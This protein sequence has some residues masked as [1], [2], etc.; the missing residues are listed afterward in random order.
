MNNQLRSFSLS[1]LIRENVFYIFLLIPFHN[2]ANTILNNSDYDLLD[3]NTSPIITCPSNYF[4]C[5][6]DDINPDNT[7]YATA[8]PGESGCDD[9]VVSYTDVIL[10]EGPCNGQL[11]IKRVWLAEY[12]NNMD[13]WLIAECTQIILLED[14][15]TPTI[16]NCPADITL[17]LSGD[18][19]NPEWDEPTASDNCLL[20]S[21]NSNYN[22]GDHFPLGETVVIYTAKDGCG[23]TSSCSFTVTITG[24][25]CDTAPEILC[26]DHVNICP[27][28][29]ISPD[30]LGFASAVG[31]SI[32]GDIIIEYEDIITNNDNNCTGHPRIRRNWTAYYSE[33]PD[34]ISTCVQRITPKDLEAP[35]FESCPSNIT[36]D[37]EGECQGIVSWIE[38]IVLDECGIMSLTSNYQSGDLFDAGTYTVV[39]TA[40]DSC[41][42]ES[43]CSFNVT[44]LDN[45]C[46]ADPIISC[47]S[48]IMNCIGSSIHPDQ[49]GYPI[50]TIGEAGCSLPDVSYEDV[51]ISS[52]PCPGGKVIARTWTAVDPN[53]NSLLASCTQMIELTDIVDPVIVD[54]PGD[55]VFNYG[56]N[57]TWDPPQVY[58]DCGVASFESNYEPGDNLPLGTTLIKY[59]AVDECGNTA[60][61]SFY[62]TITNTDIELICPDDITISCGQDIADYDLTPIF[63]TS[64]SLCNG[65]NE[66]S[67]FI[68][69]GSL[70]GHK[71]YCSLYPTTWEAAQAACETYGGYLAC[72]NSQEENY[73]LSSF[74][75][76]Q[77]AYIGFSDTEQ[78]GEFKWVSGEAV[79]Y[80]NWYPGQPNDYQ[81]G[82][83]HVEMLYTGQWNDQYP[84][85][86]LEF[87]MEI[88]C[89][90][91]IQ[92]GGPD[93]SYD[94][95]TGTHTIT[96]TG[97]DACGNTASC[98]FN[99]TVEASLEVDC[100]DDLV[101][102]CPYNSGGVVVNWNEPE[103][104]TCCGSSNG[105]DIPGFIYMGSFNG[106]SYYCTLQPYTWE[107]GQALCE[108][109]GGYLTN[110]ET[111]EE[112]Q[113]LADI[114]TIQSAYI[115]L[116]DSNQE[117][118]FEWTTGAPLN[119][120]NWYP[121]QPNDFNNIQDYVEMLGSGLWNDQYYYK[122]LECI[123]EIPGS[124]NI[125]Q[126]AGPPSGSYFEKGTTTT[127]TYQISDGCGNLE[128]C[129]FDI[130]I[131][132]NDCSPLGMNSET[133][134]IDGVAFNELSNLSGNN[135]GYGDFTNICYPAQAGFSYPI[136]LNP[137]CISAS[138]HKKYWTI[139]MDFNM[140]G[141][142]FDTN[143]FVA[144]GSGVG[145][146][147]GVI[148]LPFNIWNG[149]V[150]MR[151][152]MQLGSFASSPCDS[153]G[154]GEIEDYCIEISGANFNFQDSDQISIR[155]ESF[156]V[157][158][159]KIEDFD[160]K[161]YPNPASEKIFI[162]TEN[163]VL[164]TVVNVINSQG[165]VVEQLS[166]HKNSNSFN[167]EHLHPGSYL[168]KIQDERSLKTVFKKLII[169]R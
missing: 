137:G 60:Y 59:T 142:F 154:Y 159:G 100:P 7:G 110:I 51:I 81:T 150:T 64:C 127:I 147:Q 75:T 84:Y 43:T 104:S 30:L 42:N 107:A 55:L 125:T 67:G 48:N 143:E 148:N 156:P 157:E 9:P 44:V 35:L 69:M 65:S 58:D 21:F 47:P 80:T 169:T 164:E 92:T 29:D 86:K 165:K 93:L 20:F 145:E 135:W 151:V 12:P 122:K 25:C 149:N 8:E 123:M 141:D 167:I 45:C 113:F 99:I 2:H 32:C 70:N 162:E 121:G 49:T 134:W 19:I 119:Y 73:L 22:P 126:I 4:G 27:G 91:V 71:Y 61:C 31:D 138:S 62:V 3:C 90:T 72:I 98:S 161:I 14:D 28:D 112:N 83:D 40:I 76:T 24:S 63:E 11:L 117:G 5:P 158:L 66:I 97:S 82:Q 105:N 132:D 36:V 57:I 133:C 68:Y 101:L 15:Q 85:K 146:V 10:S 87:I 131:E 130:I 89:G 34:L 52:G 39:Y 77:S 140:D 106:S 109:Y 37:I 114:L 163:N 78:E 95:P 168:L 50:A 166:S 94:L 120:T 129:S 128:F 103:I 46:S 118:I 38:P 153:Q 155:S 17:E 18:C 96:Y 108:S 115:G 56:D 16:E 23:N 144:Y 74:L 152:I 160:V 33:Y 1:K 139:Y 79:T 54:C 41:M 53:N 111:E 88:P 102:S 136:K 116:N 26:P 13:P 6:G 124:A